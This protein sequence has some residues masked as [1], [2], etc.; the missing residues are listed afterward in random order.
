MPR[1]THKKR[2]RRKTVWLFDEKPKGKK[3]PRGW[4]RG[5]NRDT[6]YRDA[7]SKLDEMLRQLNEEQAA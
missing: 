5:P 2:R 6:E 4:H 3:R 1:H 7:S